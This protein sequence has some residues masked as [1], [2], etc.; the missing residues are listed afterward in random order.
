MI[1]TAVGGGAGVAGSVIRSPA[2]A[3]RP[4]AKATSKVSRDTPAAT[5]RSSTVTTAASPV[6][7]GTGVGIDAHVGFPFSVTISHTCSLS[8][9][10]DKIGR[11]A[12]EP[13]DDH[14]NRDAISPGGIA[15]IGPRRHS[16]WHHPGMTDPEVGARIARWRRRRDRSQVAVAAT[17]GTVGIVAVGFPGSIGHDRWTPWPTSART[18]AADLLDAS[19]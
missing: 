4:A 18:E 2:T 8:L 10:T 11:L 15:V 1:A 6:G 7:V 12:A 16:G 13:R 17:G 14:R 19:C 3:I 9:R 5:K